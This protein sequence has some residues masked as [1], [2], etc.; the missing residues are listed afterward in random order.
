MKT[1]KESQQSRM[2]LRLL[3]HLRVQKE[4]GVIVPPTFLKIISKIDKL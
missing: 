2:F 1:L 3:N 4:K